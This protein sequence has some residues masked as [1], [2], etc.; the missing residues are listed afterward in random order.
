MLYVGARYRRLWRSRS[1]GRTGIE[2]SGLLTLR[3]LFSQLSVSCRLACRRFF[4]LGAGAYCHIS[5]FGARRCN[6]FFSNRRSAC[7][8]L[9]SSA[10]S[11]LPGLRHDGASGGLGQR[12]G[13]IDVAEALL[14]ALLHDVNA[15]HEASAGCAHEGC[16]I[17]GSHAGGDRS[18]TAD[19]IRERLLV[20]GC[21][22]VRFTQGTGTGP[23]LIAQPI[24]DFT[25][26]TTGE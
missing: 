11:P 21:C 24:L 10:P 9:R 16:N 22:L 4:L 3:L 14:D 20:S 6:A 1:F 26:D 2:W 17:A 7:S 8:Q 25:D 19:I 18:S 23:I 5:S 12:F 15:A 13:R